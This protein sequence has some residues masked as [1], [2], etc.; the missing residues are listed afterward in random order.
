MLEAIQN[1]SYKVSENINISLCLKML[2][3][4]FFCF[5]ICY[6]FFQV[7]RRGFAECGGQRSTC[8]SP[9]VR[10]LVRNSFFIFYS[11]IVQ[12]IHC[13]KTMKKQWKKLKILQNSLIHCN[14]GKFNLKLVVMMEY[15]LKNRCFIMMPKKNLTD[16]LSKQLKFLHFRQCNSIHM[17]VCVVSIQTNDRSKPLSYIMN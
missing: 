1:W 4:F 9:G 2:M 10:D 7:A 6:N 8:W 15:L 16:T 13:W 11:F 5:K 12:F 3:M 14:A 17:N